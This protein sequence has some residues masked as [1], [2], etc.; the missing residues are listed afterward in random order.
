MEKLE[1]KQGVEMLLDVVMGK[2][3]AQSAQLTLWQKER[4]VAA[5]QDLNAGLYWKAWAEA[6]SVLATN[7]ADSPF[8]SYTAQV[9][10]E[11]ST[12][13]LEILTEE[14]ARIKFLPVRTIS[15]NTFR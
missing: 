15:L 7:V 1:V 14:L 4:F 13:T 12:I 2:L 5:L 8:G 9:E 10:A 11:L 6:D 3:K